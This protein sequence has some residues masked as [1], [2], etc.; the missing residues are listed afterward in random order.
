ML[1]A[2]LREVYFA[3]VGVILTLI[4]LGRLLEARAKAGTGEAIRVLLGDVRGRVSGLAAYVDGAHHAAVF[5]VED[6]AV[7]DAAAGVVAEADA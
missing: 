5:V 4:L 7:V 1:P 3:A 6:V 2:D